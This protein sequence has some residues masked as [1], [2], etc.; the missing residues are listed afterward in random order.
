VFRLA[1]SKTYST[2]NPCPKVI[3]R[4]RSSTLDRGVLVD[5]LQHPNLLLALQ[6]KSDHMLSKLVT[7]LLIFRFSNSSANPRHKRVLHG[8]SRLSTI[9]SNTLSYPDFT[10]FISIK[11]KLTSI[12][13]LT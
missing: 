3:D 9:S 4:T 12:S 8:K 7:N 10:K 11:G 13:N 6:R 5:F 2:M 1:G